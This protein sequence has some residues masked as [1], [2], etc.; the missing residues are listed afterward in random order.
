MANPKF[1]ELPSGAPAQLTDEYAVA[2][3]STSVKLTLQNINDAIGAGTHSG[4]D[5]TGGTI[6]TIQPVAISGRASVTPVLADKILILQDSSG[7]LKSS[8]LRV[9]EG[10][11]LGSGDE[12]LNDLLFWDG[13]KSQYGTPSLSVDLANDVGATILAP[14]N[15]DPAL[16]ITGGVMNATPIGG[17]TRAIAAFITVGIGGALTDGKLHI[18]PGGAGVV[19]ASVTANGLVVEAPDAVSAYGLSILT[20]DGFNGVIGFTSPT[21]PAAGYHASIQAQATAKLLSLSSHL[22]G[23]AVLLNSD[24]AT[25]NLRL[26]G[27]GGTLKGVFSGNVDVLG[28]TLDLGVNDSVKGVLNLYG[29]ATSIGGKALFFN[30]ATGDGTYQFFQI[31]PNGAYL[32]LGPDTDFDILKVLGAGGIEITAGNVDVLNGFLTTSIAGSE[33][34]QEA[35]TNVTFAANWSDFGSGFNNVS[36]MKDTNG[37][38]HIRGLA[39][40]SS[41][42]NDTIFT[43]PVGYRPAS[44]VRNVIDTSGVFGAVQILNTGAVVATI[45]TVTSFV[46]LDWI[47]FF[48]GF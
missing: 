38:V 21:T 26:E 48:V 23:G 44:T 40:R 17:T 10:G 15:V 9:P 19:T 6:L 1:S 2:R 14:V 32:A 46:C 27:I 30:S 37:F 47:S 12:V 8:L 4:G 36:F 20:A 34:T 7:V 24:V 33:V 35:F 11:V 45:G 16:T 3:S 5:V 39:V 18:N 28:G 25:L 43:L 41:Q 22:T 31:Q 29:P 42:V 13:A